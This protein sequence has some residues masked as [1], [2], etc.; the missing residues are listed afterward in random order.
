MDIKVPP[1]NS[2]I[3]SARCS[4]SALSSVSSGTRILDPR[5]GAFGGHHVAIP[6]RAD[7]HSISVAPSQYS[8]R[9]ELIRMAVAISELLFVLCACFPVGLRFHLESVSPHAGRAQQIRIRGRRAARRLLRHRGAVVF[10]QHHGWSC[11]RLEAV[12]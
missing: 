7:S 8:I 9:V 3:Y 12:E 6:C 1:V 4:G 11:S 5:Q 2:W 10:W